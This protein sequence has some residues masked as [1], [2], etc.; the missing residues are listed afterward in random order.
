LPYIDTQLGAAE[1]AQQ[2]KSLIEEEMTDFEPRDYLKSLPAPELPLLEGPAMQE[3]FSR[4]S[5]RAPMAAIDPKKFEVQKPEGEA[6]E[7]EDSWKE[8][9]QGVKR[10]MEYGRIRSVNLELL[11]QFGKKAW[12]AHSMVVRG[13]ERLLN[14]EATELRASREEV[15]KKR[16]LD[17][18]SCGNDM[19]KLMRELEQYQQDNESVQAAV[20]ELE[21]DVKR[22][23]QAA[24]D[25]GV[26]IS[27]I[28][29]DAKPTTNGDA[30]E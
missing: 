16:K 22:L 4:V 29:P 19:R 26:D 9:T 18:V 6:V 24:A 3:E 20:Q 2:V 8:A 12:V 15:N 5:M 21:L 30:A 28:D 11:E 23:R 13:A 14:N 27:S 1:V 7:V 10:Q 17:Q 25:R